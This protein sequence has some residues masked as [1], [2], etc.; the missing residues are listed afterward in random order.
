MTTSSEAGTQYRHFDAMPLCLGVIRDGRVIYA[1]ASLLDLLGRPTGELI[2]RSVQELLRRFPEGEALLERHTRR[3]RGEDVPSVFE[4]LLRTPAGER[5][6]EVSI[7][8]EGQDALLLVRDMSARA[9]HRTVLQRLAELGASL[10]GMGT[11][12][13]VLTRVFD[14]LVEL[15]FTFAYVMPVGERALLERLYVPPE[16]SEPSMERAWREGM[17]GLWSPLLER[18]WQEGSAYAPEFAREAFHFLREELPDRLRKR[19][20]EARLHVIGVRIEVSGMRRAVLV[21]ATPWLR[22]EELPPLRLFGAQVS[23]ALDAALTISQLSAQNTSL[24]ALNRLASTAATAR[25]PR[26][27]FGPGTK[28]ITRLLDCQ[29]L[30]LFLRKDGS[31]EMELVY[32]QGLDAI[33]AEQYGRMPVRGSISGQAMEQGSALVLEAESCTGPTRQHMLRQ[34]YSTVAVVPLRVR[35]RL[36]GTL[37]VAFRQRRGLSHLERETLQAMGAHFAAATESHRLLTEVRRRA[38]DLALIHEVSRKMVATLEMDL[39]MQIGVEGLA[40]IARSPDAALLLLDA[41]GQRLELR[42]SVHHKPELQGLSVSIRPQDGSLS[43]RTLQTR[44]PIIV[45]AAE[46]DPSLHRLA[47]ELGITAALMLPLVVRERAIGVAIILETSGPRRFTDSEVERASAITNQL[48]LA[49]EQARLIEDL[50]K[51]YAE[52][53]R[54]QEQLVQ[55]ERLAALGELAAVVA[56]EVRNPLG[57]I[58]N[59]VSY[60]RRLI[61]TSNPALPLV[62]IVAEEADR[63]NRIVD[64]LLHFARPPSPSP[65]PIPL[66]KLLEDSVRSA[67]TDATGKVEVEWD[68]EADVPVLVDERMIRQAFLNLALNAV[69]AMPQGGTLRVGVCRATGPRPEVQV[70]FTDTGTGIHPDLRSRIFEPFFTTKAKG[71]GLG[72]AIVKRIVESHAGRVTLE[73]E[74]GQGTT[75]R[76]FL[77]CEPE[78]AQAPLQA[79]A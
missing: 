5:R 63:L 36:V 10:P 24:A 34:G 70:E 50:K 75:F 15:G 40:L 56:H 21:V 66:R 76:L 18:T 8:V 23:A 72:L 20:T 38:D 12:K 53:A 58:F 19:L 60:I 65:T 62:E 28:E 13:E 17:T 9:H 45:E 48:A 14:G 67:L 73:S 39:L 30:G 49:L 71:T 26:D 64:D 51:S 2:G 42:A 44:M 79:E 46:K 4:L 22:E 68:L 77:P 3:M 59:S 61:G 25:E 41:Q 47:Q 11:E 6:V 29:A 31:E 78:A 33:S 69:Q 52:L 27:F 7:S 43:A 55:R 74:P 54:T 32:A 37:V 1:N 57:A 16:L 35:S